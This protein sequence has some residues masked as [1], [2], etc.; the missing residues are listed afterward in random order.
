MNRLS[1]R[2]FPTIGKFS[3]YVSNLRKNPSLE[4]KPTPAFGHPSRGGESAELN[5]PSCGEEPAEL[6]IPSCCGVR[7]ARGGSLSSPPLEGCAKRGVGL[8]VPLLWRGAGTA[9]WVSQFPSFG[10]VREA[11]GG[12]LS[13]PP[14]AG[15]S[16]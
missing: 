13:S 12:S 5:F 3:L 15:Y 10:G 7:E 11:R 4:G 8:S 1:D 9:G 14:A 6:E 2:I 16:T